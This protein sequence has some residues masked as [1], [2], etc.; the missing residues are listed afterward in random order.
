MLK[1]INI[2]DLKPGML[3][4]KVYTNDK[5]IDL[6]FRNFHAKNIEDVD[7]LKKSGITKVI[8]DL[9]KRPEQQ[10]DSVEL[11]KANVKKRFDNLKQ[12]I[13]IAEKVFNESKIAIE[14]FYNNTHSDDININDLSP[15][16]DKTFE[17]IR[18][19]NHAL[20]TILHMHRN[21]DKFLSHIFSVLSIATA[22]GHR[23]N[24]D[25]DN[26]FSLGMSALLHDI[27]WSR[28]PTYLPEKSGNYTEKE[29]KLAR[30]H[31]QYGLSIIEKIKELPQNVIDI[32]KEYYIYDKNHHLPP[33]HDDSIFANMGKLISIVDIYDSLTH[34]IKGKNQRTPYAALQFMYKQA[35]D[36]D[37]DTAILTQLIKLLGVYPV[38][39]AVELSNGERGIVIELNKEH[40]LKPIIKVCYDAG[41]T[42]MSEELIIDLSTEDFDS[43]RKIKGVIDPQMIGV[44]PYNLLKLD[45]AL[46]S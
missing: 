12:D 30:Q 25:G 5:S 11:S 4:H 8:I 36:G 9:T 32:L 20:L 7:R 39:S 33:S 17:S 31:A 19:N 1:E 37:I 35:Q 26:L 40:P 14:N 3:I 10:N 21:S 38:G 44:D 6:L 16:L 42:P 29:L 2:A 28:L 41:K 27:G 45:S 13:K 43:K 23:M 22:I 34:G 18:E 24:F 46:Q 15:V